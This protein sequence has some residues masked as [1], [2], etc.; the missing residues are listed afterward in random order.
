MAGTEEADMDLGSWNEPDGAPQMSYPSD[1]EDM[2]AMRAQSRH[3]LDV[4]ART[5]EAE[6]IPRLVEALRGTTQTLTANEPVSRWLP[7]AVDIA[8]LT[9]LAVARDEMAAERFIGDV[10]ARGAS[11]QVICAE[12]LAPAARRLGELWEDDR[13]SFTDVTTGVWRLQQIL[14]ALAPAFG[15]PT[16][17]GQEARLRQILLVPAIGEQHSFG[18]SMVAAHFRQE[19]WMVRTETVAS[20]ADLAALVASDWFDVIGFSVGSSDRLE[21]LAVSIS[22]TR[23]ASR[24]ARLGVMVGGPV[25][26]AN[27][28]FVA[29]V[30]ADA[31]AATGQE[32]ADNA[33]RLM[34]PACRVSAG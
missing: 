20:D 22:C 14:R 21:E 2:T 7:D 1:D 8:E 24:N 31:T 26:L 27:P 23:K 9:R 16:A 3:R 25:F 19:G 10:T 13:V 4:I 32:A 5:I 15:T 34:G 11:P 29:L 12:L 6:V 17:V 28:D 33:L 30:G 18:L